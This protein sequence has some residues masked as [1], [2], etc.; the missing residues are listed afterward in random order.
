MAAAPGSTM[1]SGSICEDRDQVDG[2][3]RRSKLAS[4]CDEALVGGG[5]PAPLRGTCITG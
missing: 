3:D 4:L 1:T 5:P 2:I